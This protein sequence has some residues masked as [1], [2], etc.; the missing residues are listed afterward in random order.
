MPWSIALAL[1]VT[2]WLVGW[3]VGLRA[4]H[5]PAAPGA[6]T[7]GSVAVIIPA[8][9]EAHAIA[10]AVGSV[11]AQG[12]IVAEVIVVDDGSTDGTADVAR[13]AGARVV[14]APPAPEGWHGKS[15]ACQVGADATR[16]PMLVFL[17]ADVTLGAGLLA[18]VAAD[19]A[20][21]ALVSVQPLHVTPRVQ[22][23]LAAACNLVTV[24]GAAVTGLRPPK[25]ALVAFGPCLALLRTTYGALGGHAAVR[26]LVP[27]DLALA[28]RADRL[29]IA[30]RAYCG[31]GAI[32]YRM[33]P[34]GFATMLRG[35][36]RNLA[37]GADSVTRLRLVAV[38]WWI[39]GL[40]G[41]ISFAVGSIGSAMPQAILGPV[42]LGAFVVQWIILLRAAGRFGVLNTV[43][44]PLPLA[45]FFVAMAR[46]TWNRA[47]RRPVQWRGR[48][49]PVR[50]EEAA[51]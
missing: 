15:W 45:V 34:E 5:V 9:N 30:A 44:Y 33:Y 11:L 17:D 40:V 27:E 26:A 37:A 10:D 12:D 14:V 51:S 43:V 6:V 31:D 28:Q 39:I 25:R 50:A 23:G 48:P 47:L 7:P 41:A 19:A 24:L 22:E 21:G 49:V 4:R 29:G 20:D 13:S 1:L 36:T 3:W 18:R 38:V 2:Q 16:A 32:T 35:F 42:V 46:S 8:R